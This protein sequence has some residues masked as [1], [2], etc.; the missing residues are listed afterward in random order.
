MRG[1]GR[2]ARLV[3]DLMCNSRREEERKS[4]DWQV[5]NK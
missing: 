4:I 2:L 1:E 3:D 5:E